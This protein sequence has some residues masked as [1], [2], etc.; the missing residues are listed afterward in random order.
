MLI[1]VQ[2]AFIESLG[3]RQGPGIMDLRV[4]GWPD[5]QGSHEPCVSVERSESGQVEPRCAV[6]HMHN[7]LQRP[8][9]KTR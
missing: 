1:C 8:N 6:I 3:Y 5:R 7:A 9:K 2:S 4:R